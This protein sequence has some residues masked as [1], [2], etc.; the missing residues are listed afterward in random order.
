MIVGPKP[1]RML[2]HHTTPVSGGWAFTTTPCCWRRRESSFVSANDGI[3]VTN[4]RDV[5]EEP[6]G[7]VALAKTP[8]IVELTDVIETTLP[9]RT[10]RRKKGLYGTRIRVT[11][12]TRCAPQKFRPSRTTRSTAQTAIRLGRFGHQLKRRS[13][14]SAQCHA[15]RRA[16]A[17]RPNGV[18]PWWDDPR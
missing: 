4:W 9:A 1:K 8:W 10:C 3:S 6:A 15:K 18:S 12:I 2:F 13:F 16:Q 17:T 14:T 5:V 7:L 11:W